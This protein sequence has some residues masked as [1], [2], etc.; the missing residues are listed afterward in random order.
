M[1]SYETANFRFDSAAQWSYL[2]YL[3]VG[4]IILKSQALKSTVDWFCLLLAKLAFGLGS[5]FDSRL[6]REHSILYVEDYAHGIDITPACGALIFSLVLITGVLTFKKKHIKALPLA[7]GAFLV[8]QALNVLRILSLVY[9]R[10]FDHTTFDI[11][12]EKM[13]PVVFS[14]VTAALF[15]KIVHVRN[16]PSTQKN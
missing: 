14:L 7:I 6:V 1:K 3:V 12:H 9:A 11:I 5:V 4:L 13:W 8:I 16:L 2:F 15:Y 10:Y